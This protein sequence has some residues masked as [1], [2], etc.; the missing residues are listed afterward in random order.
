MASKK[1]KKALKMGLA[2]AALAGIGA[3]MKQ[4]GEMKKLEQQVKDVKE[5]MKYEIALQ[6]SKE[7][8]NALNKQGYQL[9]MENYWKAYDM[10]Q[11]GIKM[12]VPGAKQA[13]K[14]LNHSIAK[15]SSKEYPMR[16]DTNDVSEYANFPPG[17]WV[18]APNGKIVRLSK[19]IIMAIKKRMA[20]DKKK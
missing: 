7:T 12:D 17:T 18:E 3:K 4:A 1:L 6:A 9:R 5:G 8:L 14:R 11:E 20:M 19:K 2:G 16:L 13:F 10:I 15:K